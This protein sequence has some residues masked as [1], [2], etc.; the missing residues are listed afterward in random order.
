MRLQSEDAVVV[1]HGGSEAGTYRGHDEIRGY[2]RRW[3]GTWVEYTFEIEEMVP[4]R[5]RVLIVGRESAR[6]R[7]SG[8]AVESSTVT[9]HTVRDGLITRTET[10][11]ANTAE[12][13]ALTAQFSS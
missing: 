3:L 6:G 9:V 12:L 7:G 11:A 2:F 8:V 13:E 1:V 5:D 4:Q 10:G